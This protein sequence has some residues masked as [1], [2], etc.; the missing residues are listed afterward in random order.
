MVRLTAIAA[1]LGTLVLASPA[2]AADRI[3]LKREAG[4]S[5][6]ERGGL[7]AVAG[8]RLDHLVRIDGV[9]VVHAE[10][11][12]RAE[13]LAALRAHP[14]VVWAEPDRR[15]TAT[16][17]PLQ[18][19]LWGLENLAQNVGGVRGTIDDD[20]DAPEAWA[21][22]RG[23]GVTVAVVDSG[24]DPGHPDLA[25]RML[26]GLD[27]VEG[28]TDPDDLEGH[29]T[30]VAG[31]VAA[32][33]NGDGVVGVAPQAAVLPLRVLDADGAGWSSDVAAAF[34]YA[35]DQGV[36]IVNASLGAD[37]PTLAERQAI[38]DHP[39]TLYVVAAG[40]DEVNVEVTPHYPCSYPEANVLCVGATD[41]DDALAGFS[42]YGATSVDLF[43][44]GVDIVS[45][46]PR[47]RSTILDNWYETGD[48]YEIMNGTSMA[49]PH[50]SGA[51]ALVA[52][53][54]PG[55]GAAD[56]KADLMNSAD[57]VVSLTGKGV[58][59]GRLNAARA[60]GLNPPAPADTIPPGQPLGA[61]AVA[62][63]NSATLE[64]D[65]T[66]H[67]GLAGYRIYRRT[68]A[69]VWS[70]IPLAEPATSEAVM[71]GL[72]STR[73][74]IF[75]VSAVDTAGNESV[76]RSFNAVVPLAPPVT[77]P[78]PPADGGTPTI[79]PIPAAVG[80]LKLSG[81]VVVCA[82]KRCRPRSGRLSFSTSAATTLN[83]KLER[84]GARAT[85]TTVAVPAGTTR[86]KVSRTVAGLRVRPGRYQLTLTAPAGPASL[87][88]QVRGR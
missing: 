23:A 36:R 74:V 42:N 57:P 78:A 83:V 52:A 13:A 80:S 85:A 6:T 28:D 84:R 17:E 40:N 50:V 27:W 68:A 22:T 67:A 55:Y 65:D 8:V 63:I 76:V 61:V 29:G 60:L 5:S 14:D 39:N 16:R 47:A 1:L 4:L 24:A 11:G 45:D 44:P 69:G 88:F 25:A 37:Q 87:G 62:G 9:E 38:Q 64:W 79:V 81:R 12:E 31:T 51:A 70:V 34:D 3:V 30:H 48:G 7:R 20:I 35:G 10:P 58:I 53:A 66:V 72:P 56:I 21:V 59:A 86:W 18:S 15:V 43:A 71:S 32:A 77:P 26:P 2:H 73:S 46:Y 54:H 19:Q 33:D 75:G 41:Q 49:A 82:G